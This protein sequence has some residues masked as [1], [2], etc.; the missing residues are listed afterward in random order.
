V[1][2]V[3][4]NGEPGLWVPGAHD[5]VFRMPNG[6][7]TFTSTRLAG[8]TLLWNHGDQLLRLESGLGEQQ[9]LRIAESTGK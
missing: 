8:N 4:V 5:V 7:V 9:A 6:A 3:R 2:H 1:R